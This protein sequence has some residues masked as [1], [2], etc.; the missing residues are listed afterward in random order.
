M[1]HTLSRLPHRFTNAQLIAAI[2]LNLFIIL[3]CFMAFETAYRIERG[4]QVVSFSS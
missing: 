3:C 1:L 4:P 2:L